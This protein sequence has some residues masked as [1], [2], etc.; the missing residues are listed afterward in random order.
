LQPALLILF[1]G[2]PVDERFGDL[3]PLAA[4]GAEV[5]DALAVDFILGDGL[6]RAVFE[7]EAAGH[8]LRE[9]GAG[10]KERE[11]DPAENGRKGDARVSEQRGH[12]DNI[13]DRIV[14]LRKLDAG[15]EA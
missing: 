1:S 10:E 8:G 9:R 4:L 3:F 5:A 6:V 13:I 11:R 15:R 2:V 12:A 14:Y 7:D